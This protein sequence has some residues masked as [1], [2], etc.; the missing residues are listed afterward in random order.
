MNRP[1][2]NRRGEATISAAEFRK[3]VGNFATGVT[4]CV[5]ELRGEEIA[6]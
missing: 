3:T 2:V 5:P 1:A 6:V 4:G